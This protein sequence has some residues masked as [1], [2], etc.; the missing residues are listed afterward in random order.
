MS[1]RARGVFFLPPGGDSLSPSR[2]SPGGAE[3]ERGSAVVRCVIPGASKHLGYPVTG[4]H[5]RSGSRV[6]AVLVWNAESRAGILSCEAGASARGGGWRRLCTGLS[7]ARDVPGS[8]CVPS[9]QK[10]RGGG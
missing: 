2:A 7:L 10:G 6:G 8:R 3:L 9:A 5:H 1:A 4:L